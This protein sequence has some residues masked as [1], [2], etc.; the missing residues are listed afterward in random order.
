MRTL[1]FPCHP[2]RLGAQLGRRRD[3]LPCW[4]CISPK[5]N[6]EV[7]AEAP[8][9]PSRS[10]IFQHFCRLCRSRPRNAR[11]WL[12]ASPT[13]ARLIRSPGFAITY[14]PVRWALIRL[15]CPFIG[16]GHPLQRDENRHAGNGETGS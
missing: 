3:A 15:R 13:M 12:H 2:S 9:S 16:G 11:T 6:A 10:T 14:L 8:P 4:D 7:V 1:V 5:E